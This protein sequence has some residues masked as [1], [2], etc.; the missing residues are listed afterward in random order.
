MDCGF[1][2][3]EDHDWEKI[4]HAG[5]FGSAFGGFETVDF[6]GAEYFLNV[7]QHL[8]GGGGVFDGF[9]Y[10]NGRIV[11]VIVVEESKLIPQL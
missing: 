10:F 5:E 7:E 8:P 11:G 3:D 1:D 2:D 6:D 9:E 4:V